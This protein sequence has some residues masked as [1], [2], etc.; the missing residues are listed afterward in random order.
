M[1]AVHHPGGSQGA[2]AQRRLD[3]CWQLSSTLRYM[4]TV[5]GCSASNVP[6]GPGAVGSADD[7]AGT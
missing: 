2:G 6:D 3:A 1:T 4:T 5:T 7:E